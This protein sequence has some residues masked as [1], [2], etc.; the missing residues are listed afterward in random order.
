M[1]RNYWKTALSVLARRKF[2]T[3]ANLF[4][5][6]FT[7]VVLM[8]LATL[9]DHMLFPGGPEAGSGN[10]LTVRRIAIK[11]PDRDS[12]IH[13]S[14]GYKFLDEYVRTLTT[15]ERVA[16]FSR[17]RARISFDTGE[18]VERQLRYVDG[19]YWRV[20]DFD[21]LEGTTFTP[22]DDASAQA[23]AV[24]SRD[25][26]EV[27]FGDGPAV[28]ETL[29][30]AG[31]VL[32]VVGVVDDVS[33]ILRNATSDIWVPIGV[34]PS[35][36]YRDQM[37]GDFNAALVLGADGNRAT[38]KAEYREMLDRIEW[39][40]PE[41]WNWA[42]SS[43]DTNLEALA[44]EQGGSEAQ[45]RF[46]V[47]TFGFIGMLLG[48]ILLFTLLPTI[49]MVNLNLS[50]MTE[51]SSEIGVRKSFGATSRELVGQFL[52]E[53]LLLTVIGGVLGAILTVVLLKTVDASGLVPRSEFQFNLRIFLAGMGAIVFV[54]LISGVYPAW[55]MSRLHPVDALRGGA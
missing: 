34:F 31:L 10:R 6:T 33:P 39:P 38:L 24:I 32:R 41:S 42:M 3:F 4:G 11:S 45:E 40:D 54:A 29:R 1:L 25:T 36:G 2:F 15:P 55:R 37:T 13:S 16:V 53:Q 26:R 47:D 21:V 27:F 35:P 23:V 46:D 8:L 7:L 22:E 5:I 18:R 48:G 52:F 30:I 43:P 51:R 20:F 17:P 44:R 14:P 49:N 28:G 9:F 12:S 50:R 19:E